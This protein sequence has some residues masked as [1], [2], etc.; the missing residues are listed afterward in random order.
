MIGVFLFSY[1]YMTVHLVLQHV[2]CN[3]L[4]PATNPAGKCDT[5]PFAEAEWLH[6]RS[7]EAPDR[8]HIWQN[9]WLFALLRKKE[10]CQTMIISWA[11]CKIASFIRIALRVIH[12]YFSEAWV[13]LSFLVCQWGTWQNTWQNLHFFL[14]IWIHEGIQ[15]WCWP[16]IIT[17]TSLLAHCHQ[18]PTI[19]VLYWPSTQL[20]HIVINSWA[21]WI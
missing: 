19:A 2:R 6:G 18:E 15:A 11:W 16:C 21:N 9:V 14:N 13:A 8:K 10:V 1:K 17:G 20:H 5:H 12:S 3:F 7:T 4:S